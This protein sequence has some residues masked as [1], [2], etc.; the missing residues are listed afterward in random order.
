MER[1]LA[2][3]VQRKGEGDCNPLGNPSILPFVMMKQFSTTTPDL[4]TSIR[5]ACSYPFARPACSYLFYK[6]GMHPLP[7][8]FDRGR[9]PVVASGSNA[10]PRRLAAKFVDEDGT[11]P[12]TR[13]VLH[14]FTVVFAGHFTAYGAIPATLAPSPKAST[15]VWI[16][17]LT[18]QQLDI[19]H[20]SEGVISCR[21]I[22]QRYDYVELTGIDLHP[23]HLKF[24]AEAGAYLSRRMLAIEGEPIRFAEI[25]S[26]NCQLRAL[27]QRSTLRLVHQRLDP[28]VSFSMFMARVLSHAEQRQILFQQL[29]PDTILRR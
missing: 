3:I 28:K 12:V 29:T 10:A 19:M 22:E 7:L 1:T 6:G 24:V 11:I 5:H 9:I 2:A 4:A 25:Y 16:T 26:R 20:R 23:Q 21:E 15:N 17:W 18:Q 8:D 13:A 14:G 27:N